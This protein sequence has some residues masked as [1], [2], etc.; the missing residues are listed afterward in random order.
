MGGEKFVN[1]GTPEAALVS[2]DQ[3]TQAKIRGNGLK[4]VSNGFKISSDDSEK[5]YDFICNKLVIANGSKAAPKPVSYTH[6]DVYKR[7][8]TRTDLPFGLS[9]HL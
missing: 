1:P 4:K 6:L 3:L 2:Y 9:G 7:Q 5:K 8:V